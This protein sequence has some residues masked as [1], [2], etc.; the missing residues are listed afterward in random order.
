MTEVVGGSALGLARTATHGFDRRFCGQ[1]RRADIRELRHL[2]GYLHNALAKALSSYPA[3]RVTVL[4]SPLLE[5]RLRVGVAN[6]S[7]VRAHAASRMR[8]ELAFLGNARH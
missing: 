5:Q 7:A 6:A 8:A 1:C 2:P 4:G 3:S